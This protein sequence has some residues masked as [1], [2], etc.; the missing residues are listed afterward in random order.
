MQK[1]CT[2][3]SVTP[4]NSRGQSGFEWLQSRHAEK[5]LGIQV[6]NKLNVIQKYNPMLMKT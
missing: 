3:D 6:E 1:S 5:D 4:G 2:C